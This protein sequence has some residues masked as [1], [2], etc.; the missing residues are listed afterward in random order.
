MNSVNLFHDTMAAMN[1]RMDVVLWSKCPN[2][3]LKSVFEAMDKKVKEVELIYSKFNKN[4]EVF[5]LNKKACEHPV[6]V[7]LE[8]FNTIEK[9][10]EFYKQ[11]QGYFNIAYK[12][13][14]ISGMS[15][16]EQLVLNKEE[17]TITYTNKDVEI[18]FGGLGKGIALAHVAELLK[19]ASQENAFVSFGGSSIITRGRHPYGDFWPLALE[20]EKNTSLTLND[21]AVSV[22]GFHQKDEKAKAHIVDPYKGKLKHQYRLVEIQTKCPIEAEV[23]STALSIASDDIGQEIIKI[24]NPEICIRIPS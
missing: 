11:T 20:D 7:S 18:D 2:A 17:R 5:K 15:I 23:L 12:A 6:K 1:S 8:L 3:P 24:F 21:D 19:E 22:S 16:E 13:S 4:A 9:C 14:S 10:V